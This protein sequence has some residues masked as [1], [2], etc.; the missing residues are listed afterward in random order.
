MPPVED[1]GT[2]EY[3]LGKRGFKRE[4]VYYHVCPDCNVQAV[5]VYGIAGRTGGR[6]IKLCLDCGKA[7]SWRSGAGLEG[8][9]EDTSFD[10]KQ[11]LG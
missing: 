1:L 11:F 8:R 7:R 9:E 2:I 10:L 5:V 4:D 6:D 3:K